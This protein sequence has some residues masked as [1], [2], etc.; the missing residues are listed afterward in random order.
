[1]INCTGLYLIKECSGF[2]A[3]VSLGK[4]SEFHTVF[5]VVFVALCY[6]T[7]RSVVTAPWGRL[8]VL[9]RTPPLALHGQSCLPHTSAAD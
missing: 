8:R 1:M 9:S 3:T 4:G 7:H 5:L 6:V 2:Q